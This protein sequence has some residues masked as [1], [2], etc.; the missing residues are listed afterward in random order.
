MTIPLRAKN[1]ARPVMKTVSASNM[2]GPPRTN[3]PG[4]REQPSCH[5]DTDRISQRLAET[6]FGASLELS[7][8]P[9]R[10]DDR[11]AIQAGGTHSGPPRSA[12]ICGHRRKPHEDPPALCRREGR[13]ALRGCRDRVQGAVASRTAV[14][15]AAGQWHHL[16]SGLAGL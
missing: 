7:G 6:W 9:T 1:A 4:C 8:L 5:T 16:P 11:G 10:P 3:V 12:T 13:V 15:A 14:G 2:T